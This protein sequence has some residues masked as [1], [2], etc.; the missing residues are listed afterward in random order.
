VDGTTA[1]RAARELM[2]APVASQTAQFVDNFPFHVGF[3][4]WHIL[5]LHLTS[6]DHDDNMMSS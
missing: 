5:Q 2:Q 1:L 3:H 4:R 6:F